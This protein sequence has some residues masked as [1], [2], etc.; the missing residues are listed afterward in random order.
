MP[1]EHTA[2]EYLFFIL[3]T[4]RVT[5]LATYD[6]GPGDVLAKFRGRMGVFY[7]EYSARQGRNWF[8]K[9]LN[10]HFCA[11]MWIGWIVAGVWLKDWSFLIVGLVLSGGSLIIDKLVPTV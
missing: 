5:V 11:S 9:M 4:W 1:I 3:L 10:C 2:T 8:A 6:L 7:D